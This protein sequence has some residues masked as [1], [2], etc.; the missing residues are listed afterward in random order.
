MKK[1]TENYSAVSETGAILEKRSIWRRFLIDLKKSPI[2][3]RFGLIVIAIYIF[4]AVFAVWGIR[5]NKSKF[6]VFF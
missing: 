2:S 1:N 3:A 5:A 4:V 6:R